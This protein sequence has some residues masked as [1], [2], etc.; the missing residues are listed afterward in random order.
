VKR[1]ILLRHAKSDW[2]ASYST[3]HERP[4]NRRGTKAAATMGKVLAAIGED[5]DAVITSSALRARTTAALAVEGAGWPVTPEPLESLYGAS[6]GEVIDVIRSRPDAANR[7]L[8]VGH[9]P[10][11]SNLTALLTGASVRVAT[12]TAVGIDLDSWEGAGPD[13]GSLV[14]VLPPRLVAKLLG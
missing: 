4:L 10:T 9:E 7:L 12:A 14:Y 6:A 8:V 5:P 3:D 13:S 11:W 1:L 2:G